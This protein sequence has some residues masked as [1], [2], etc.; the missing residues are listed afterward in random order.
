MPEF[1]KQCDIY[2]GYNF[3]KDKQTTVGFITSM[4]I[5]DLT[6]AADTTCKDPT[7]PTSDLKVVGVC[8]DVLW[9][10]GVTDA[11]YFTGQVSVFNRQNIMDLIINTMTNILVT[12]KFVVYEYDPLAKVYFKT[13][14]C[15]DTDMNGILEK[16]GEDLNLTVAE[17]AST[18][19]QSPENYTM[20]VGIKPQPSAQS[21]TVCSSSTKN[22]VK[23]WGLTVSS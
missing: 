4:K 13:F 22:V 16:K 14:H 9:E 5:G 8:S 19:V 15:N 20:N 2:Q 17:L 21:L 6:I 1:R 18:E 11:V 12:Y 10:L 23:A 3:K 7:N